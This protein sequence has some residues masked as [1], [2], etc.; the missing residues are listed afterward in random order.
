MNKTI[1]FRVDGDEGSKA[2]LGHIYRTLKIYFHLKKKFKDK[3]NYV[4]LSRYKLGIQILKLK[5]KERV[6]RFNK[7]NLKAYGISKEDYILIDT[8]GIENFFLNFL[9]KIGCNNKISFDE[10]SNKFTTGLI[11]NGIFFAKKKIKKK[12]SCN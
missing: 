9:N 1:Y 3:L 12:K 10:L 4:F 7:K 6:I 11:I 8:L 2:G 5:T